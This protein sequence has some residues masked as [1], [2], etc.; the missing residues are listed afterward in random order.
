[1]PT[2]GTLAARMLADAS[3]IKSGMGLTRQEL[4]LT[5]TAFLETRTDSQKL[6]AGLDVL[7][8]ANAKG[9]FRSAAEY[10]NAVERLR[11]EL[12][13]TVIAQRKLD[14][15]VDKLTAS[16]KDQIATAGMTADQIELYRLKQQG[17]TPEVI[18]NVAALQ[19]QRNAL[20]QS[21]TAIGAAGKQT[22]MFRGLL[23][24][25]HP[26]LLATGAA[27][28]ALYAAINLAKQALREIQAA[29]QEQMQVIDELGKTS[30]AIGVSVEALVG[31]QHAAGLTGTSMETLEKGMQRLVRRLGEAKMGYGEGMKAL[32]ALG[33]SSDDLARKS[34]E[35]ALLDIVDA[36]NKLPSPAEKAAAAYALFGRQ[37]QELMNFFALGREGIEAARMET[38]QLGTALNRLDAAKVEAAN[39]ALA[40]SGDVFT[41]LARR[42]TVELAPG[43]EAVATEMVRLTDTTSE[44]G[45][46]AHGAISDVGTAVSMLANI[47]PEYVQAA[48][49]DLAALS[50]LAGS[51]Q[52]LA[53][54]YRLAGFEDLEAA[55]QRQI[56]L[57]R[58]LAAIRGD[59][60]AALAA[61]GDA[62]D[63]AADKLNQTQAAIADL[64]LQIATFGES[65]DDATLIKLAWAGADPDELELLQELQRELAN[66]R[67]E[68]DAADQAEQARQ[69]LMARGRQL[70]ESLMT[71]VERRT[72]AFA[73]LNAM[74]DAGAIDLETYGR[75]WQRMLLEDFGQPDP[76]VIT[77]DVNGVDAAVRGSQQA[78]AA[79][80]RFRRETADNTA[81]GI[82][83]SAAREAANR[84]QDADKTTAAIAASAKEDTALLNRIAVYLES[85]DD[86]TTSEPTIEVQEVRF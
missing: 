13:P 18:G 84:R 72:Q 9:A 10:A 71:D 76:I 17:A 66:L 80:A 70:T 38:E 2:I 37:G 16:L 63:E 8:K 7:A 23:S 43:I 73:D 4:R 30:D 6:Q 21:S 52:G 33:L 60:P 14:D 77:Y 59:Q 20:Q 50:S 39:D 45:Y 36:I 82:R 58:Q 15:S 35:Q 25:F 85:I 86:K 11:N 1:M 75:A 56:E 29:V 40:R 44:F 68:Q 61:I 22:G 41:G 69:S 83:L 27:F 28:G 62:A 46:V 81:G 65:A 42:L 5:R 54:L 12:D 26:A 78:A 32:T 34:P 53:A 19:R 51:F 31:Y 48:K 79:V 64:K 47:L 3:G 67:A 49:Q 24:R 55:T 74:L 57:D